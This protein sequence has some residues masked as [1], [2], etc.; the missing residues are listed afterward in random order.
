M[1]LIYLPN[2]LHCSIRTWWRVEVAENLET[3]S[4]RLLYGD[5]Q[6]PIEYVCNDHKSKKSVLLLWSAPHVNFNLWFLLRE[7]HSRRLT[8]HFRMINVKLILRKIYEIINFSIAFCHFQRHS[9]CLESTLHV[10][11]KIF[12][13]VWNLLILFF[14]PFRCVCDKMKCRDW[15]CDNLTR[16]WTSWWRLKFVRL[17]CNLKLHK[18]FIE[19]FQCD[20]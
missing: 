13:R 2:W 17:F 6:S 12:H 10:T 16:H 4:N 14:C 8:W 19:K 5:T 9:H 1:R 11:I 15:R 3:P 18:N 7:F 20:S